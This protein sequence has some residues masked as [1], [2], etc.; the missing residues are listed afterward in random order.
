MQI[1]ENGHAAVATRRIGGRSV[2]HK[3]GRIG[4]L[5]GETKVFQLGQHLLQQRGIVHIERQS[6][7]KQFLLR[8]AA[9]VL[10]L[11]QILL[12][13]HPRM[14]QLLV[15]DKQTRL[16]RGNDIGLIHLQI[17]RI[18]LRLFFRFK[19]SILQVGALA[20]KDAPIAQICVF[21]RLIRAFP[22]RFAWRM[23]LAER[24]EIR[25]EGH[26]GDGQRIRHAHCRAKIVVQVSRFVEINHRR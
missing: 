20:V 15:D 5:Q 11:L 23:F 26:I 22:M 9:M 18:A 16:H 1:A 13:K 24:I 21:L 7:R 14:G 17:L 8:H 19:G 3:S 4:L 6:L 10:Q 25:V 2:N 12:E